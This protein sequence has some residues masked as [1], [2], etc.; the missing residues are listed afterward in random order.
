[1]PLPVALRDVVDELEM[2]DDAIRSYI[3]S[4]TGEIA[5]VSEDQRLSTESEE[6]SED[7]HDWEVQEWETT[8]RVL[9]TPEFIALPGKFEIHEWSIMQR[10]AQSLEDDNDRDTLLDAIH[11]GGAFGRF[12]RATE[13][14]GVREQWYKFRSNALAKIAIEFLEENGIPYARD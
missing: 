2:P 5:S 4:K 12:K 9:D 13:R 8:Q 3:N 7:W 6:P 10:F 11:G 14:L 1:M